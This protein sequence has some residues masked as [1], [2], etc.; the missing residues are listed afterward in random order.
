MLARE[1]GPAHRPAQRREIAVHRKEG[2]VRGAELFSEGG[3]VVREQGGAVDLG[4]DAELP[5]LSPAQE[6]TD[7]ALL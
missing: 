7:R 4:P 5:P 2:P 1:H 3:L 6:D